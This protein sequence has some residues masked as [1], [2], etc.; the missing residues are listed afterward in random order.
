MI[1]RTKFLLL[2]AIA[3]LPTQLYCMQKTP[4]S[5]IQEE[6]IQPCTSPLPQPKPPAHT[7]KLWELKQ[8]AER[9]A[10]EQIQRVLK[11]PKQKKPNMSFFLALLSNRHKAEL[12]T[13]IPTDPPFCNTAM[14]PFCATDLEILCFLGDPPFCSLAKPQD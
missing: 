8:K 4:V 6:A 7:V 11:Q 14:P 2:L 12:S 10:E 3:I 1:K 5:K 9:L 13:T